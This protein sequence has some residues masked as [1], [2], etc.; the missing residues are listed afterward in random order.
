MDEKYRAFRTA[1][2][3]MPTA[4]QEF[5]AAKRFYRFVPEHRTLTWDNS[6]LELKEPS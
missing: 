3:A 1:R 6:R 5:Y 2:R 4:T